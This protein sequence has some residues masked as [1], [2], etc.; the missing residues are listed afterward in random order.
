MGSRSQLFGRVLVAGGD[1]NQIA[2]T[3]DDGPNPSATPKLLKVLARHQVQATFF[4]IGSYVKLEPT[5]T[6]EIA[7]AGHLI[8]NHTMTHPRLPLLSAALIRTELTETKDLLEDTIGTPIRLFR[9]PYGWRRPA[10]L[11]IA[12]ELGMTTVQW[13]V[14][15]GDWN[16]VSAETLLAR[17]T[18]QLLRNRRCGRAS[19]IVLHDGGQP[20]STQPRLATVEATRLLLARNPEARYVTP[21]T[22]LQTE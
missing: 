7:A 4:L 15:V 9:P 18:A 11:R 2:L 22:W 16:P 17:L 5:L 21:E 10:V 8:G 6:R 3:Y 1:P 20:T 12:R 13:N 19:N 14:M